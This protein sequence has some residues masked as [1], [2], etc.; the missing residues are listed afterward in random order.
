MTSKIKK[1][2]IIPT[3]KKDE[4]DMFVLSSVLRMIFEQVD[5]IILIKKILGIHPKGNGN[6]KF[7]EIIK[8]YSYYY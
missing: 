2:I 4:N 1:V 8:R 3:E 6:N 5:E 7:I